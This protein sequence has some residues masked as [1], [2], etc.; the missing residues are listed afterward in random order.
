MLERRASRCADPI[1]LGPPPRQL[2]ASGHGG[3][4]LPQHQQAVALGPP[5]EQLPGLQRV[6]H[7][8]GRRP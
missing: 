1:R 7:P 3:V 6:S 4:Q 8:R 2:Q 5:Q